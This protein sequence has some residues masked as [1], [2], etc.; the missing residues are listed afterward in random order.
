MKY[1]SNTIDCIVKKQS[2]PLDTDCFLFTHIA[3]DFKYKL[4]HLK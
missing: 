3:L 1:Q 4:V 2:V